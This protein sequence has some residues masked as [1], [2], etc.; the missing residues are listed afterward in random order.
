MPEEKSEASKLINVLELPRQRLS[1]FISA[2]VNHVEAASSFYDL[3]LI[4]CQVAVDLQRELTVEQHAAFAM[5]WE[6][7]V[8]VR[9]LLNRLI[10]AYEKENGAIRLGEPTEDAGAP[11]REQFQVPPHGTAEKA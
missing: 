1:H 2:Y 7:A 9:N 6:H 8:R 3:R 4:F 5:T 10:A 11:V